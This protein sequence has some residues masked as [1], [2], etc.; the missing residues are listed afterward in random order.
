MYKMA[1][2]RII[3]RGPMLQGLEQEEQ[4]QEELQEQEEQEQEEE[5]QG[6]EQEP[7]QEVL[8][9]HT[10]YFAH[11]PMAFQPSMLHSY[12]DHMR[13]KKGSLHTFL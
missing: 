13:Q 6:P 1:V 5:L 11:I 4:E 2:I 10:E 7:E 12:S 9:V 3:V 8:T